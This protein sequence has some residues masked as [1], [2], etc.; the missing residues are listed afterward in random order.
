ML[1]LRTV[2]LAWLA[3]A[4]LNIVVSGMTFAGDGI[5]VRTQGVLMELNVKQM[6]AII[7]EK[8]F[9]WNGKTKFLNEKGSPIAI[10]S[11][12]EKRWVYVEGVRDKRGVTA[13]K[14][15]LLPGFIDS[16]NR[17]LYPFME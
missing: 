8:L 5:N 4:S 2:F 12:K 3:M 6:T 15:Y 7:N 13:E 16:K 9:I 1:R 10:D 14:I 11:F 17:S